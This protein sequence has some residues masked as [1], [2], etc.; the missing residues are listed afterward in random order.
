MRL[1]QATF[2]RVKRVIA[3]CALLVACHPGRGPR[4]LRFGT[5]YTVQQSGALDVIESLWTGAP[6][7]TVVGPSGQILRSA[8]QGDLDVVITHAP[9]LEARLLGAEHASLRCPLVASRF[10]VVGP[11]ADPA[12]VAAAASAVEAF[13]R[14][15]AARGPFVSRGDSSGTHTKELALWRAAGLTPAQPWYIES[16]ADQATTLHIADE[17]NAYALADLPTYAK[18]AGLGLRVLFANDTALTNPY[19]L[20]VVRAPDPHAAALPFA[21][22]VRTRARARIAALHLPDGTPAFAMRAGE[23]ASS[24]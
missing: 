22:W 7:A 19:T 1:L 24:W 12:R 21:R 14:I 6:L 18:L 17:R 20:Y 8:A 10:A 9:A 13:R 3:V 4:P 16:G 5:T 15:V 2:C 23:C 11:T